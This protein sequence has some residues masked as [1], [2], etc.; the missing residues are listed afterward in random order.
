MKRLTGYIII[1]FHLFAC[2]SI[3]VVDEPDPGL[4]PDQTTSSSEIEIVIGRL[5][6][7]IPMG[8]NAQFT[9]RVLQNTPTNFVRLDIDTI[10]KFSLEANGKNFTQIDSIL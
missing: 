4:I 2:S 5:P 1:L 9:L 7:S 8:E 6:D 3:N 10:G